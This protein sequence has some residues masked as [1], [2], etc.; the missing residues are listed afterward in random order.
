MYAL[1]SFMKAPEGNSYHVT[2][3][4]IKPWDGTKRPY[5]KVI[6]LDARGRPTDRLYTDPWTKGRKPFTKGPKDQFVLK[7]GDTIS[8][9]MGERLG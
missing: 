3:V 8:T 6:T 1:P 5:I 9:H 2:E 4:G 7:P